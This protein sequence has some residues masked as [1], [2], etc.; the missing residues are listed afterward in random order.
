M[1]DDMDTGII[2]TIRTA[3]HQAVR[4]HI[5]HESGDVFGVDSDYDGPTLTVEVADLADAQAMLADLCA[6]GQVR[7]AWMA[8]RDAAASIAE[9]DTDWSAFRRDDIEPWDTGPDAIRDYRLG[10]ATGGVIAAQIRRLEPPAALTPAPQPEGDH[11]SF[12]D[13]AD[14]RPMPPMGDD[15]MTAGLSGDDARFVALQLARNGLTLVPAP[16]TCRKCGGSLK[17]SKAIART[18]VYGAPDDLGATNGQT[19]SVGGPG[20][21]IDCYKCEDC[22]WSVTGAATP[23]AQEAVPTEDELDE[24]WKSGFNA[25][26]GE[27]MIAAHP[28]RPSVSVADSGLRAALQRAYDHVLQDAPDWFEEG[29]HERKAMIVERDVVLRV[30]KGRE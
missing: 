7:V 24:A 16:P 9:S 10:I 1:A 18:F 4:Y 30:L 6:S 29:S 12:P 23:T 26:F 5:G 17:P 21:L 15:L 22:G 13:A 11:R 3:R 2:G 19:M 27:A 8:G 28:P 14:G 20:A 25:G